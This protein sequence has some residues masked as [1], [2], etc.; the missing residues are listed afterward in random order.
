MCSAVSIDSGM[1]N[2]NVYPLHFEW[3]LYLL[4]DFAYLLAS[5]FHLKYIW[6]YAMGIA[7]AGHNRLTFYV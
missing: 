3:F 7:T 1:I 2:K 6:K 5:A 4:F